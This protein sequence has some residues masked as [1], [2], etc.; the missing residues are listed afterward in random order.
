MKHRHIAFRLD[1]DSI[2]EMFVNE[3]F[4]FFFSLG[5]MRSHRADPQMKMKKR[6]GNPKSSDAQNN[7][8]DAVL[9]RPGLCASATLFRR[10]QVDLQCTYDVHVVQLSTF[11]G[12]HGN[13]RFLNL[14]NE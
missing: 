3:L 13:K 1:D 2:V 10:V 4:A 6:T 7:P 8:E 12:P 14:R 5:K 9:C 11:D